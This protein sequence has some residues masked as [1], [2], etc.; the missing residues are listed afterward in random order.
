MF[1]E[2]YLLYGLYPPE[3][4]YMVPNFFFNNF[5]NANYQRL[6]VGAVITIFALCVINILVYKA[7]EK[8]EII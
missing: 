4:I 7:G 1:R 6:S 2:S 5:E 8:R 3:Q